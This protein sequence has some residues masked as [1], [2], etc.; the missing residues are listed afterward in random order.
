M[1]FELPAPQGCQ[2]YKA[3]IKYTTFGKKIKKIK[4]DGCMPLN[5]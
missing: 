5:N 3:N 4:T 1:Q 2:L